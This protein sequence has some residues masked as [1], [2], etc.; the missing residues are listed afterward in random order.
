[1]TRR[2]KTKAVAAKKLA[3]FDREFVVDTFKPLSRKDRARWQQA[4]NKARG[5]FMLRE[6]DLEILS[7]RCQGG[8]FIRLLHKPTGISRMKGPM[9]GSRSSELLGK[10]LNDIEAEIKRR[11]L[12]EYLAAASKQGRSKAPQKKKG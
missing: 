4:R 7:G 12:T 9:A 11:G 5:H 6:T 8:M 10:W 1:M 3:E 2:R